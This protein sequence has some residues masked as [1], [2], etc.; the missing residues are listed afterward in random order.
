MAVEGGAELE[1]FETGP[2]LSGFLLDLPEV[3][4]IPLGLGQLRQFGRVTGGA[5]GLDDRLD[6]AYLPP[7]SELIVSIRVADIWKAPILKSL[8]DK[9]E[10]QKNIAEMREKIGLEP[11]DIQSVIIGVSGLSERQK[12]SAPQNMMQSGGANIPLPGFDDVPGIMVVRTSKAINKQKLVDYAEKAEEIPIE[13]IETVSHG[14]ETYYRI[15]IPGD[16]GPKFAGVFFPNDKTIVFGPE[17]DVKSAIERGSQTETRPDLDFIDLDQHFLIAVV[18][19]D[20]SAFA[21]QSPIPRDDA[22]EAEKKLEQALDS[23]AP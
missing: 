6:L 1:L 4:F 17:Q 8:I 18:P 19:R 7:D 2:D 13:K 14:G 23:F 9:P 5:V 11:A 22:S 16:S 12:Q 20:L 10:V 15:P 21:E 3:G